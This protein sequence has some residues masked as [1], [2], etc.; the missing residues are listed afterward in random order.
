MKTILVLLF[1][2]G[3]CGAANSAQ[4][5]GRIPTWVKD[6]LLW[7]DLPALAEARKMPIHWNLLTR[8]LELGK[9]GSK[10][11][12]TEN[13]AWVNTTEGVVSIEAPAFLQRGSWFVPLSSALRLIGSAQGTPLFWDTTS[14]SVTTRI[15]SDLIGFKVSKKDGAELVELRLS[16]KLPYETIFHP[17]HFL[18]RFSGLKGDS[19]LFAQFRASKF[20]QKVTPSQEANGFQIRFQ[21]VEGI[22]G[23]EVLEQDSGRAIQIIFGEKPAPEPID[24][25]TTTIVKPRKKK[26]RTV[27][28]D[29]GHG[30]KDPGALGKD[31]YEKEVVLSV[32]TKLRDKLRKAGFIVKMT[33]DDD[34]FVELQDRPAMAS[35]WGGDL[36]V[37]LHCNAVD[38]EERRKKTDG[39]RVYILREAE[40][41]EDKAI[42][43]RENKAAELSSKKR[44]SEISPVEWILLEN[45]LNS[46]TKES[47]HLTEL[48]VDGFQNMGV[49]KM[50]SGAGQAGF[51]V[52]VGAFM[53]AILVELG[54]ITHPDD[55]KYLMSPKGQDELAE[56]LARSIL[57]Y[58][59]SE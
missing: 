56:R 35:K 39:Y 36:F 59:D 47:E 9:N 52:L 18:V 34:T 16:K 28:I 1:F 17:P 30:G 21:I 37:S 22:E 31:I 49:R 25:D 33:R 24:P 20:I 58:R 13:L 7:V 4:T 57:R 14:H 29:P 55:E 46:F 10:I 51:M 19:A 42:A 15:K 44:K 32:G 41:E 26:I 2:F 27:V 50:G 53:P 8:Q 11:T 40:S 5:S 48:M 45:Q 12:W 38:G 54:F 23:G 3:I 6:S 43:R